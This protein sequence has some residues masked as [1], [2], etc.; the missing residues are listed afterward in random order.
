[1]AACSVNAIA[2]AVGRVKEL[3]EGDAMVAG[4]STLVLPVA[5]VIILIIVHSMFVASYQRRTNFKSLL[6]FCLVL[7]AACFIW[8]CFS[9]TAALDKGLQDDAGFLWASFGLCILIVLDMLYFFLMDYKRRR[10]A[11]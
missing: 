1:M 4:L 3:N 5:L 11:K 8:S 9:L 2:G 7:L 6:P 10:S